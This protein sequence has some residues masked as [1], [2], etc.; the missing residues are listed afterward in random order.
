M[1]DSGD[2]YTRGNA[3]ITITN[4][5]K[6]SS[7]LKNNETTIKSRGAVV[8]AVFLGCALA[9][10]TISV[11]FFMGRRSIAKRRRS[12]HLPVELIGLEPN[13]RNFLS[14]HQQVD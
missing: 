6:D 11:F 4:F 5:E 3:N 1:F 7:S 13:L 2:N 10:L 12:Q 9:M 8:A 14:S